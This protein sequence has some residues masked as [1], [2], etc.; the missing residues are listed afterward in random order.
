MNSVN[1]GKILPAY[2]V[3]FAD[4]SNQMLLFFVSYTSD[5]AAS[6]RFVPI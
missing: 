3:G 5:I 1:N 4:Y 2:V 6:E